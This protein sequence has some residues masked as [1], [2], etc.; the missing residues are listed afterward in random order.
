VPEH[1]KKAEKHHRKPAA[2]LTGRLARV[3]LSFQTFDILTSVEFSARFSAA[4]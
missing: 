1:G 3:P 2:N 4:C